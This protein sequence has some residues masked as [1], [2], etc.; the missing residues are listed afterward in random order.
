MEL[1][2]TERWMFFLE[3]C[4][5]GLELLFWRRNQSCRHQGQVACCFRSRYQI[6]QHVHFLLTGSTVTL[7]SSH[8]SAQNYSYNGKKT[9]T[10]VA[11]SRKR[12]QM[13]LHL[14]PIIVICASTRGSGTP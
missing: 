10:V 5:G 6:S 1:C 2:N 8:S 4:D 13:P 14:S 11:R 9:T 12:A 7:I 3:R